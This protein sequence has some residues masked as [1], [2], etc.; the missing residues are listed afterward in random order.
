VGCAYNENVATE[1]SY[2]SVLTGDGK[3]GVIG[4]NGYSFVG[5]VVGRLP[6]R[7]NLSVLGKVGFG[8]YTERTDWLSASPDTKTRGELSIGVSAALDLNG[9]VSILTE[10]QILGLSPAI[11]DLLTVSVVLRL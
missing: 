7:E 11:Y 10:Y 8:S 3:Q 5:S 9:N 6:I 4:L 1:L 2:I